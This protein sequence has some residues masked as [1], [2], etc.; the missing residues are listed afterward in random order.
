M[1]SEYVNLL[2][3][4][5][6]SYEPEYLL[7]KHTHTFFH[8]IMV[9]GGE[10]QIKIDSNEYKMVQN[11]LF[12]VPPNTEHSFFA[13]SDT[14]L[15]T[16]EF[17]FEIKDREL[18]E[19]LCS[20]PVLIYTIGT[21]IMGTVNRLFNE[22]L[23]KRP[24]YKEVSASIVNELFLYIKR[25]VAE[26]NNI[27]KEFDSEQDGQKDTDISKIISYIKN[28]VDNNI[29]LK[30]LADVVNLEKTYFVKKFKKAMGYS[31][32][33][34]VRSLKLAKAQKLLLYSDMN[35][36][37][38]SDM[39]SFSSIHRFSEFFFKETG[40]SPQQFRKKETDA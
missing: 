31:P 18:L 29:T 7:P 13:A 15:V 27:K 21:P 1:N 14:K 4:E 35:I 32:M 5:S 12:F 19:S 11:T 28:N 34:Y 16:I 38:I 20:F 22:R 9:T 8:C 17:K 30:E 36:T 2:W 24:Y 39:L 33:Q 37:Q 26:K 25:T 3:V 23:T 6:R 40:L 10:G